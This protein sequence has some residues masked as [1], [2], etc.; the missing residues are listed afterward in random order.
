MKNQKKSAKEVSKTVLNVIS[1]IANTF[2]LGKKEM[3]FGKLLFSDEN[4]LNVIPSKSLLLKIPRLMSIDTIIKLMALIT[5][6][7]TYGSNRLN[8]GKPITF[9]YINKNPLTDPI[10]LLVLDLVND[11][12]SVIF[13]IKKNESGSFDVSISKV[14]G[15][16]KERAR[17]SDGTIANVSQ[18][19]VDIIESK[20]KNYIKK[21]VIFHIYAKE[22]NSSS[23]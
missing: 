2:D 7:F 9:L 5:F 18:S 13:V 16:D 10:F 12:N 6:N 4:E 14:N 23:Y 8:I 15:L 22:K 1:G 19:I 20:K 17:N 3:V 21:Q 11:T